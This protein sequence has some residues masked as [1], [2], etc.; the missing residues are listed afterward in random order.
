[1]LSQETGSPDS[2]SHEIRGD[3]IH[4]YSKIL[5]TYQSSGDWLK[6]DGQV[7]GP[8]PAWALTL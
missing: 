8:F 1:M 5:N 4:T 7:T 6:F 2:L 3:N